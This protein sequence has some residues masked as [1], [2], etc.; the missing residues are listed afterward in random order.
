MVD[1]KTT[2]IPAKPRSKNYPAGAVITRTTGS[3][4]VNGG[5]GGGASVDIV[6]ATDTKSFTDSNVLS[7]LRT[8]LEIRSRIIAESD[9]ATELTDDNALSSKRTLKEIDA[10]IKEA[11]KKLDDVYLSKVKADTAAETITFLKGLLI[12]NDLAFIN[13][14]GDAELQSLVA[15]MKVKAATLEVTGAANVGTL[16][17]EGNI[18]TGADIWAKGDTYTLNLL[19]QAL[20]KTYDLNV[21]HVATLFQT[22]VK[23]FISSE[24]F[25]P[26]LMGEGMKLYKAINGD[27]NLEIDNAVVRKAMTIFELI[28][29]K[30]RAVN[31]GL[32]ISSANGRVKSVSETSGDPAYYVLGIEGD[33]MFVADDLVRCQVYTSGHVKYYWVPVAS[34]NDD[35]ILILK[36][37]LPN[38]T[39]PAVGDDLVQMG[40]LT[41]P[42]RQGILYL[43]ASEDGKP[44]ISVLDGVNSTSLA[45]KNKVILGCLDGMTDTDFPADL[46]PSGYGLYAMNCFLKGIFIL[47][48][49]K[50]IEQEFS[51]IATELAAIPGKIELAIRS[52]KV[53]DVNLLYDSNNK[54]NANPYQMGAYKYDVHLEAGK[55]Y[56]LTVCY[57]CADSDVIRAYN[58]PS[59]GWI[60]TLPKSAEE[61]VLSQPIT[62]INPDGAYFY[63]YK[64]PQQ[65]S[66]GTYIK[67]AVITEGSVGVANWIPSATER[68]LN[69]GGEN[70]MLQSQQAL[71]GS[72]AQYTFQLSKAWTDLK[73]KTLTISFD[74]AYSNLKMGSSQ[75]FG[76][77]KAIYK[78]GTSQ[79]YYIGAF[80]YVDSTSPT[81][82]KGRYV[83]TIKVPDDIEDSLDTDITAYIQL[84]G[85]TVCRINNFQ[86]E[87]GDT[88]TG[89]KPAPK[90]SFTESKKYTD[91]Q[92]LAV[93]GKI[94]LSVKTKVE[95]LGIGANN[96]YSYTSTALEHL[97]SP[98]ITIERQVSLH[99]FYLVGKNPSSAGDS[100]MRIMHVIPP[101]PG[102]YTV[103][104]WIKGS[105]S[106]PVG[107]TIDVC[108]SESY[109][110]RSTA[111]N[112]WSYFKHTFDVTRN[113]E[114]QSAT[115]HFVDLESISWAY[116]WV[117][118]F[119]VEA[120]EIAT[121]WSPNFQDAVYKGAEYTNSQISVVEGKITSTVEKINT[122]D[123]RVTGL[124]SRVEQTEKSITS[125]VGDISVINSTTNRHISKR[126]DLRGWD[127]NKF[128]P[129]V[130]S[131]PVYH[132]TRVEISRPLD[133]GYGKPS[134]GTHD[135]GFSMNLTFEMSGSGWGSLP[136]VTNIFDYTKAW[137]SAGAKIVVDLG[138]IT[139]TSTCRMGIRGG[140]MYD[141]TVDDTI[142]PNVI[143]VYQTDYHGSYNT[144][145]PVRTD[146]TEPVRTY[147]YYTEIKQT[148]ESI[149]LTANKVDDQGRRL[150]AA[151]LTLSSDH[152]KLGVVEQTANSANSLAGTANNKAEAAD[153][154]VTAIQNGL[155][156]T[157]INI[158]SRKIV[159]KSDNVLFQNNAG[160]QTVAINANGKL[161]ANVIEAAEVVAQAFSAQ[162]ITTGNLTVTDG[163]Y[164]GGWQ[165]KNNAIYSRNV[166]D[167]KIQLE[168]SG[169][170]FLR[171]NQYGG[172]PTSGGF[173]L[174]EIR[175]DNQ[176]CLSLSTYGQG[177]KA[178][179]IIANS[180]GGS[181]I[182]SHGS[183]LFG[184]RAS[185]KWNAPGMLCTGYVY[186][187]G[188]VANKWGNGCALTSAQKIATGKYRIYHNLNH[189]QYAVL[190][191]GLGG[192]GWVFGQVET[193]SNSY[194]EVLMLDS[195]KGPRDC[196]FLVFV[197]GRN[198]W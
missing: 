5:G 34:V 108:D 193:Q 48:N 178:L 176:D 130:I 14:S 59:Y 40:N 116:I 191:Q 54:L 106:T 177:G 43:T 123:G 173:P 69:I 13:E 126:I 144:S 184:Q 4:A 153:S 28:I 2:S 89:W 103:S 22:I 122:V 146:G 148:Q 36:S 72:S 156:E 23:D 42:N 197:V 20:A 198:V 165:I 37:V 82:D 142:D 98:N 49:G 75:R 56:T 96:L 115:Y 137:T 9:T 47:R 76:L 154:R 92:I 91:T 79:Y 162:R 157:G 39:V 149:A 66:T 190:I 24:R 166:A 121:A 21:E 189:T 15:R 143:N 101:I 100:G 163:A 138:Q 182:Q 139:E 186:Q 117:K 71:D 195:N 41:N 50:S 53:A 58:N 10:A 88:A 55:T 158:T 83:H 90:D 35:S 135:G 60:G 160:Q 52:M 132:K 167:A 104:G 1:I 8:L 68:K 81:T 183:H 112:Q 114:A 194:F 64:F 62:P 152:A 29:S 170:R 70:L 102:K 51:N 133:A 109:T 175:N 16:H 86:I 25:I 77:E 63:F 140:S 169:T 105:Q 111:D 171:I 38:G 107:F 128:F 125:V 61:T 168:I 124:A 85:S 26:G 141:V 95:N 7:S 180:E 31:G 45:G 6:K 65:E 161:S 74:Y 120:G 32:V 147:G 46:Q 84:G 80:K 110:V 129:L 97:N 196:A 159:L 94:E 99:G 181:A 18:S 33:M 136:A 17:S 93:D 44:R 57:K 12:G 118:D 192:Y 27:W 150:S 188:T 151:E 3:V 11:L 134:Y 87:I 187:A 73:G 174:M 19:V 119:K 30:V 67:W 172:A 113:T 127:N 179:K 155:V 78:S 145:F 185:E 164:L 131:I